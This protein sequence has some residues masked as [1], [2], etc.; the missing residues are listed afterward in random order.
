MEKWQVGITMI[1]EPLS[2]KYYTQRKRQGIHPA[3]FCVSQVVEYFFYC[4][5]SLV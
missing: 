5:D 4:F 2:A 1:C 3:F